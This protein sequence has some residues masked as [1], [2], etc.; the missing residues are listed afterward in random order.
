VDGSGPNPP[1]T[2]YVGNHFDWTSAGYTKYYYHGAQ[3]LA[4]RRNGYA[5]GNGLF[6]LLTDHLGSTAVQTTSNG[7]L[8]ASMK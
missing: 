8:S 6:F 4:M 2:L 1:T 7:T 5:S 3:R